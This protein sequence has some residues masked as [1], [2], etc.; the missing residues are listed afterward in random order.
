MEKNS[1]AENRRV[2]F[3]KNH[4]SGSR[5]GCLELTSGSRKQVAARLSNIIGSFGEVDPLKHKWMPQGF[6]DKAEAQ[7]G[8]TKTFLSDG[9]R[10]QV[11]KWWL[12]RRKGIQTPNWDIVSDC[13][14]DG[15]EGLLLVEAKAHRKELK[16]DDSCS[17]TNEENLERIARAIRESSDGLNRIFPGWSLSRDEHYQLCN[18]WAW[19]WKLA[20]MGIPVILIYA[21]FLNANEMRNPFKSARDWHD[22]VLNYAEN[23]VPVKAWEQNLKIGEIQ[24]HG[25]IRAIDREWKV[26]KAKKIGR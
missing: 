2:V 16:E 6:L 25:L 13:T 4:L 3:S 9:Q 24:I 10:K 5:L 22:A 19:S 18:R 20:T 17:S 12:A 1:M 23:Y 8:R 26:C 21:G 15:R 7:L 14:I 11:L